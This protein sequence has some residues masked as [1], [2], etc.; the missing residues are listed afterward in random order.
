ML[1]LELLSSTGGQDKG[2]AFALC[3][4]TAHGT[5][6]APLPGWEGAAA[7]LVPGRRKANCLPSAFDGR[8]STNTS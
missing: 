1:L 6:V 3:K 7:L 4:G 5:R 8:L 2:F